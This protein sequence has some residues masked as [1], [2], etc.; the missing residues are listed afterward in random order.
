MNCKQGDIAQIV[1]TVG[2]D[3]EFFLGG[4]VRCDR[5]IGQASGRASPGGM[6]RSSA[7]CWECTPL[8]PRLIEATS[9]TVYKSLRVADQYLRPLPGDLTDDTEQAEQPRK[10]TA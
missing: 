5:F 9:R 3:A 2:E 6:F 10:V 7:D 4:L 8:S 1:R